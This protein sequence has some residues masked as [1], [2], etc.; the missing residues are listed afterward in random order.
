MRSISSLNALQVFEAVAR[1]LSFQQAASELDVTP[2]AV[3]HQIKQLETELG[4][5]L[6]RRRPRPLTLTTAGQTLFPTVQESLD[7]LH[8]SIATIKQLSNPAVLT[9]SVLNV[10]A[11]KWL[12]PRLPDFQKQYPDIDIRLQTSNAVTDLHL[13]TVDLAIRYGRGHYPG[14]EAHKLMQDRFV[15]VCSPNLLKH[16]SPPQTPADLIHYPLLHFEW[17]NYGPDAPS[18]KN[19]LASANVE[20]MNAERGLKF[21]EENLAIQAAVAGQGIA[22]CSS[23]HVFNDVAMG[24]L[25]KASDFAI[26]G[27]TYTAV[28]LKNHRKEEF[29]LKFVAW[30]SQQS[31]AFEDN[32]SAMQ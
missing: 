9:V 11:A 20:S 3:S 16:D 31:Q 10:F 15:P 23:V 21:D 2:T 25:I 4:I 29:I 5:P 28:H 1:H 22:L 24:F 17:V 6:F 13:R 7:Q 32:E 19:W 27:L 8:A 30:L 14:L 12:V 18:W 26:E